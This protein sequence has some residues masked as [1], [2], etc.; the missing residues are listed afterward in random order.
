MASPKPRE[1]ELF[2]AA[3]FRAD[4]ARSGAPLPVFKRALKDG[5]RALIEQFEMRRPVRELVHGHARMI[6]GLLAEAWRRCIQSPAPAL[7]AVGGFGRGELHPCS[8]I[9]I[10]ILLP[11][12]TS[13]EVRRQ[14]EH[15]LTFLWDLG[16]EI[17]HSVRSV[18]DCVREAKADATVATTLF[19]ARLLAGDAALFEAMTA[20]TAPSVMWAPRRFFA[21]K[22]EEQAARHRK[23]EETEHNLEPNVKEGP[24]GLRDI[25]M[26]GWVAQ[27][28]FGPGRLRDLV[29]NGFLTEGEF[30][31]LDR[32]RNFLWQ[33]RF[34]LHVI[35]GRREDRLLFDH[36]KAVARHFGYHA[37]DN[38]GVE[39]FMKV[40]YRTARD[41]S[42]LVEMLLQLFQEAIIYARRRVKIRPLN[43][44]FQIQNDF[45]EVRSKGIFRRYPFAML[46]LFL[47]LQQNPG[48]QGVRATTIRLVRESLKLIDAKFR[49]DIR[50]R[51]LF[52]E[53]IRQPHHVGHELRRM[54]RYGVLGAYLPQFAAVE[55][56]MQF[57]LFH[58]YTVDVHTLFVVRN[59]RYFGVAELAE[60]YPPLCRHVLTQIP[61]QELLYLAGIF[62]DIAKGR[63][64]DHSEL[65]ARDA[66]RFC[67][68]HMLPEFDSR[69]VAWLV[70]HH[71]LMSKT[72]QREDIDDPDT[73]NRFAARVGDTMHLNYLYL[74]TVAD[75]SATNPRL[76]NS[77]KAALIGDLYEKTLRTLRRGLENPID[78]EERIRETKQAAIAQLGDAG[79]AGRGNI[80]T[81]W[82]GLGDDYFLRHHPDEIAWHS[83]AIARCSE[84]DLPLILIREMTG[85]GGSEIFIY[86]RDHDNIFSRSTRAMDRLG[87]NIVDARI[88][89]SASGYTLDTFIVLET[90]GEPVRGRARVREIREMLI[91]ALQ[92]LDRPLRRITHVKPRALKHFPIPTRVEFGTDEPNGRTIMEVVATDRPGFLSAVGMAMEFCGARLQGAKI[93]TY[94]ERVEDIFFITDRHNR[95]IDDEIRLE[96]LRRSITESLAVS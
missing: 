82:N 66:L 64:G 62:H 50:N 63:G 85:R 69:L 41:L 77:W 88:I 4:L 76:W 23:F 27:R 57:D 49:A 15:F 2:D 17:G 42:R 10:M 45:I 93:S 81:L 79:T 14:I 90:S 31:L 11:K 52:M 86:M 44:R 6:D 1:P 87:L 75:I 53:I 9:D 56:Q 89:T 40:Y 96:C 19:E 26:I 67:R 36:Q 61:K 51:S 68:D 48:I 70:E 95:I 80:E 32:G 35:T 18:A 71:L 20:A 54:H 92:H 83:H 28:H 78:R 30:R 74:L 37:E 65:G 33:V 13:A 12:R 16:L 84:E 47:L 94:G 72:A 60:R 24:G 58:I 46:E 34:A 25:Q 38:A 55:G 29:R 73:V 91:D 59:M 21:A 22:L 39:Q 7:T 43:N 3:A 5:R 8:D